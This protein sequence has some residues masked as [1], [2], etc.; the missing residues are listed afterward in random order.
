[1]YGLAWF[2][3]GT[4]DIECYKSIMQPGLSLTHRSGLNEQIHNLNLPIIHL[5]TPCCKL[6]ALIRIYRNKRTQ[7]ASC[8]RPSHPQQP[9][10]YPAIWRFYTYQML[11]SPTGVAW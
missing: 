3:Q 10:P 2:I 4:V 1:M 8:H 11:R 6:I 7:N 9:S 5:H